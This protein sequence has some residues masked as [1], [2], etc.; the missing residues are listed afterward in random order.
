MNKNKYYTKC[1]FCQFCAHGHCNAP[2][3]DGFYCRDAN[4]ELFAWINEQ[5]KK[6]QKR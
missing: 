3:Q 1:D 5:K 6:G 2:K 4:N